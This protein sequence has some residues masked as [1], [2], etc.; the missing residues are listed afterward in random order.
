MTEPDPGPEPID[1][2][3]RILLLAAIGVGARLR[4]AC[5]YAKLDPDVIRRLRKTDRK[6]AEDI[7]QAECRHQVRNLLK[8][9]QADQLQAAI[10][11][12][13]R[14]WPGRFARPRP[15]QKRARKK[16]PRAID[17]SAIS[18]ETLEQLERAFAAARVRD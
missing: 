4:I 16:R 17:L 8:L 14:R 1:P 18:R 15:Q 3:A 7:F 12:L 9:E 6:L 13:E 5:G 2:A 11:A 10:F